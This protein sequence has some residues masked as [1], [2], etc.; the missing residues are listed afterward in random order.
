MTD[1]TQATILLAAQRGCSQ[2]DWFQS[3]HCFNFGSYVEDS[4]KPFGLLQVFNDDSLLAGH[5]LRMTTETNA[6][7]LLLPINGG[8]DYKDT[9]TAAFVVAGQM[10]HLAATTNKTY[11][12][13][14]PYEK[15]TISFF[16]I[17]ITNNT[18]AFN[19]K[20]NLIDFDLQQKNTLLSLISTQNTSVYIG[21]YDGRA[22]GYFTPQDNKNYVFVFVIAGAFEVQNRLLQPRDGLCLENVKTIDFEALS[23]DAVL[24]I[25]TF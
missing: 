2:T 5:S 11:Q 15:E 24:L 21:R 14:N 18:P 12:I 9:D 1:H 6:D 20:I 4:R 13:S 8:F 7:I 22:E 3:F 10:L 23:N 16:Q 25:I 17:W 19:P